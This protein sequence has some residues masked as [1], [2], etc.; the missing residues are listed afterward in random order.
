[1]TLEGLRRT[2]RLLFI[3]LWDISNKN[4]HKKE[5]VCPLWHK[6]DFASAREPG[7]R[8][9][10]WDCCLSKSCPTLPDRQWEACSGFLREQEPVGQQPS[11]AAFA[12]HVHWFC[13]FWLGCWPLAGCHFPLSLPSFLLPLPVCKCVYKT[14]RRK[15]SYEQMKFWLQRLTV[16]LV[17]SLRMSL[18]AVF[19]NE[20][21]TCSLSP[22]TL[23]AHVL[24]PLWD[25]NLI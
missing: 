4:K 22:Y 5:I 14:S 18:T 19:S 2:T 9:F 11:V 15:L 1:M 25:T 20:I 24:C 12:F 3:L 6:D 13:R 17:C 23:R 10:T 16:S 8:W 21:S 7:V